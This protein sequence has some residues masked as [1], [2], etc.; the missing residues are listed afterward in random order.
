MNIA[1][2]AAWET[3]NYQ[4][5]Y[6]LPYTHYVYINFICKH[7]KKVYLIVPVFTLYE[8]KKDYHPLSFPNLIIKEIPPFRKYDEGIKLFKYYFKIIN[9]IKD[10]D[11]FYCR[12][13]DPY[14]W[15]PRLLFGKKSIMHYVGDIIDATLANKKINFAKRTSYILFYLPEY[16]LTLLA[17]KYS[18][19]FTC[20]LAKSTT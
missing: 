7:F 1:V 11:V 19:V 9:S 14:C 18:N 12:V 13:P 8:L 15:M 5:S 4:K 17:S 6:Y 16:F 2:L 10:T 20:A 3:F